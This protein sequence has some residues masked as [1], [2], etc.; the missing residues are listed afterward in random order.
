M[1]NNFRAL[2]PLFQKAVLTLRHPH[3]ALSFG[4]GFWWEKHVFLMKTKHHYLHFKQPSFPMPMHINLFQ[5][6]HLTDFCNICH[7]SPLLQQRMINIKVTDKESLLFEHAYNY[8]LILHTLERLICYN[9]TVW[10]CKGW[11]HL[12]LVVCDR[13]FYYN[14][15]SSPHKVNVF[16]HSGSHIKY[17]VLIPAL[18]HSGFCPWVEHG[19]S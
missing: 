6:W 9:A 16:V 17:K 19:S 10:A 5:K 8:D 14:L 13:T 1:S 12:T 2:C 11:Q 15:M 4:S 7:M 18:F 3:T